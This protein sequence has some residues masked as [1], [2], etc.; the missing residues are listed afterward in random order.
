[1]Q[2][3]RA[4]I[5]DYLHH[6]KQ[7]TAGE[8]SR[9]LNLTAA[10]IRHHLGILQKQKVVRITGKRPQAGRGRPHDLFSLSPHVLE[11]N[12]EGLARSL[13]ETFVT[14]TGNKTAA[15]KALARTLSGGV[16]NPPAS[17]IRRFNLVLKRL[18][19][20]GYQPRWEAHK[21]GPRFILN[22]CPYQALSCQNSLLCEMD[23]YLL[24]ILLGS[25]VEQVEK[26]NLDHPAGKGC[27][28]Q[29]SK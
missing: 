19:E 28:F 9:A 23:K 29:V 27:V 11:D 22:H 18:E 24:E 4:Q 26:I 8:L 1:M 20:L 13:L 25:P 10:N 17:Q 12:L 6:H 3:T 21:D 5:I 15:L 2:F 16:K 7:A 14:R